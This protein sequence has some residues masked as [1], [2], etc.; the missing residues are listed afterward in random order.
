[1]V[2]G[3][4]VGNRKLVVGCGLW[5]GEVQKSVVKLVRFKKVLFATKLAASQ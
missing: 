4:V 5:V 1:M 2:G 3:S